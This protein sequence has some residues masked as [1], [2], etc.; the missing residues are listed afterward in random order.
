MSSFEFDGG[1]GWDL[2]QHPKQWE[3]ITWDLTNCPQAGVGFNP[4]PKTVGKNP[5]SISTPQGDNR[6]L[7]I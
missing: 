6:A 3:R 1:R 5:T 4:T 2:T 7:S